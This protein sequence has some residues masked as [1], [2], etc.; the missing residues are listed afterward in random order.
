MDFKT[1]REKNKGKIEY[2]NGEKIFTSNTHMHL[3]IPNYGNSCEYI[4]RN[5]QIR[6]DDIFLSIKRDGEYKT[7][8]F[9]EF[10]TDVYKCAKSLLTLGLT[11]GCGVNIN[12]YNNPEWVISYY[13]AAIARFVP[14]GIYTTSS[15]SQCEYF[16]RSS[17][18]EIVFVEDEERLK[19]YLEIKDQIPYCKTIVLME[20]IY[21][22]D[23][24]YSSSPF[25]VYKWNDFLELGTD[26]S[27]ETIDNICST[28]KPDDTLTLIFTSGTTS[29]PK[30][31]MISHKNIV[32]LSIRCINVVL[33]PGEILN[34][35]NVVSYL[36]LS[37]IA[38][39]MFS[40]ISCNIYG[41]KVTFG[42]RNALKGSLINT[43]LDVRPDYF[44]GVPRVFEKMQAKIQSEITQITGAK[45]YLIDWAMRVGL[46]N[47]KRM[48]KGEKT[49]LSFQIANALVYKKI[50]KSIGLEN[51]KRSISGAAPISNNTLEFFASLNN[52]VYNCYGLS[53]TTGPCVMGI[54]IPKLSSC[55]RV[56]DG[57]SKIAQDGEILL[58][59]DFIFK[60]YL[61]NQEA[62]NEVIDSEGWFHTGDIGE[63][64]DEGFLIITDRKKEIII[65]AGGENIS[66][67]L[68]EG[69]LRLI[70]G[71]E[72]GVVIGDKQKFLVC[73][74][75]VNLDFLRFL[76]GK[77]SYPYKV[78][79]SLEEASK[80]EDLNKY[81]EENIKVINKGLAQVQT[82][83]RFKILPNEFMDEGEKS[84]LTS[85]KKLKR[86]IIYEK[87]H[88]YIKE[89]YGDLYFE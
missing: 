23:E 78:P 26:I 44:L 39:Q 76:K 40:L 22:S 64:D 49:T 28:I 43:L 72:Q 21:D 69:S 27:D 54:P 48:E 47:A 59:G 11:S 85:T 89:L 74:I 57:Q 32:S 45:R 63:M 42:D 81:I 10:K 70:P 73:L 75:T 50:L 6:P 61:N 68:I 58:R 1:I 86:K 77:K 16:L 33:V 52:R 53:E 41:I 71:V 18:G 20:S 51:V 37:H 56:I 80:D 55:G 19:R 67:S 79:E 84:E 62:T 29:L 5:A 87:Y 82:I 14:S 38:E 46:D 24:I 17:K 35:G 65:T 8:S 34:Q 88:S 60:G 12:S 36:P 31:C 4:N 7:W 2:V 9:S 15:S 83:K 25:K 13:G 30:A 66:P 3:D